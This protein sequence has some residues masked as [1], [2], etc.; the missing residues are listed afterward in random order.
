MSTQLDLSILERQNVHDLILEQIADSVY[1]VNRDKRI[2]FWNRSAEKL[3]GYTA[4]EVIGSKCSDGILC[5]VDQQVSPD[6]VRNSP[7]RLKIDSP[8]ISRRSRHNHFR[9]MFACQRSNILQIDFLI[10]SRHTVV[11]KIVKFSRHAHRTAVSQVST[12]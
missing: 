5:H 1:F 12:M 8:G 11:D 3:T 2:C 10:F 4:D 9:F 7:E 6:L